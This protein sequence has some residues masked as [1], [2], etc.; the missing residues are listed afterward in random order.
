MVALIGTFSLIAK[1]QSS[2][3]FIAGSNMIPSSREQV[4]MAA[5]RRLE[6]VPGYNYVI[7]RYLIVRNNTSQ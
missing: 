3:R 1:L 5:K 2:Q 6:L 7:K 4:N